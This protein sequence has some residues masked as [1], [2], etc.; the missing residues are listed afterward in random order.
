M[1]ISQALSCAQ[2]LVFP[3]FLTDERSLTNERL[4]NEEALST[5]ISAYMQA[6][7]GKEPCS[8]EDILSLADRN[9]DL[10]DTIGI[11]Q[12]NQLPAPFL[13]RRLKDDDG[14]RAVSA[15]Q[16]RPLKT[17]VKS[18]GD[19]ARDLAIAWMEKPVSGRVVG[20]DIETTA[21]DPARGYIINLGLQF[22]DIAPDTA[23][24]HG[25]AG[26][27]G[28]PEL[29]REKGV[30]LTEIHKITWSDL[31]G[32]QSFRED[33]TMHAALL[34]TMCTYPYLAHNAAFED[35]WFMLHLPGYA[36]ARK[37]GKIVVVD[38]RDL[39]R[40]LDPEVKSL[41]RE[42]RPAALESWARRR[43]ALKADEQ[44]RHL[45]LDDVQ[46]MIRTVQLEFAMRNM[47]T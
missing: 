37:A 3:G 14:L 12:L 23:P 22:W 17:V 31:E 1:D 41:P 40:K 19:D 43:G 24:E 15:L 33:T 35:S 7:E 39:C 16:H 18:A 6:D 36:E 10:C 32:K 44:E 47:Y 13:A 28:L 26:W 5:L 8:F 38:T 30:P 29:Y 21:R 34:K 42:S 45:G 11:E 46:L 4:K 9:R 2:A 27:Y 25:F 20:I